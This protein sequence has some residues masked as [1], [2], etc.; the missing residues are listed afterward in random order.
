MGIREQ[1]NIAIRGLRANVGRSLLTILGI[2]IGVAAI[3]LVLTLGNG[4]QAL[5]LDQ[6]RSI[7]ANT[8]IVRPGRQPSGPTDVAASL[9]SNTLKERD[10][11][12][13]RKPGNAPGIVSVEPAMLVPDSVQYQQNVYR[14]TILGWSA[15]A[16]EE[17]FQV[18]P[19]QGN[20]FTDEDNRQRAKVAV[21]GQRVKEALFGES[22]AVG[23]VIKIRGKNFRVM[24]TIAPRG[25]VSVVNVD[26]VVLIPALTAQ[27]DLL[28]V[29]Y[30]TEA[31]V[32]VANDVDVNQVASDIRA[33]LR[34]QHDIVDPSKDDFYVLTQQGI[35]QSISTV[36]QVLKIFLTGIASVS[37]L[38]G[39]IGIMNIMLVSVTERTREIGLRKAVGATT[40]DILRQFLMESLVLTVSGGILG[41]ALAVAFSLLVAVIARQRF[42]VNWPFNI[43]VL[44]FVLG[45][46]MAAIVGLSFGLY[47]ARKASR[48]S[49][50]EAL[51][52]E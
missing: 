1:W 36:T 40:A 50:M 43:S 17:T 49:P 25:Q 37:L 51:R 2:V 32:R 52:Y 21:I 27:K 9:L 4:A 16:L 12:A 6:V 38:V 14:P 3:V 48:K 42:H 46:G 41:T 23:Q 7:G 13:L 11:E 22:D 30:Y 39:G 35:V 10:I 18:E 20:F 29:D 44:G 33:T 31:F 26:E 47:P 5:I 34:E 15:K 45:I 8:I 19:D 24:A 28:G